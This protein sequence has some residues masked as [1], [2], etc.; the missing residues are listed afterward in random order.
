MLCRQLQDSY[1]NDDTDEFVA[2]YCYQKDGTPV[3]VVKETIPLSSL[4]SVLT[5]HVRLQE[6]SVM[7]SLQDLSSQ[8]EESH[9][10]Y[11][12]FKI[13]MS[14]SKQDCRIPEGE[15]QNTFG[16][17]LAANGKKQLRLAE[18]EKYAH[19]TFF[20]NGGVEEPNMDEAVFL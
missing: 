1:A 2:S 18:T 4:T 14:Q 7:M 8:A 12:C 11:V 3:A 5:V 19:V 17:Y 6:H 9:V 20:F 15:I 13:T 10:T 16:E